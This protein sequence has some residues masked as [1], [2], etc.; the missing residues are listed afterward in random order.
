MTITIQDL[1]AILAAHLKWIRSEAGGTRANLA[2]ANL[3]GAD[4]TGAT[5]T[6]ANL[7]GANL[8]VAHLAGA[9]LFEANL[10]RANLYRANLYMADLTGADLTGAHLA[11]ANLTGATIREGLTISRA[12]LFVN[13]L[14][15]RVTIF[16]AHMQIGC[17]F[18]R[19]SDWQGFDNEQIAK[20][21]GRDSRKFW[22]A[23]KAPLL[24]MARA[25]GRDFSE[26]VTNEP[27]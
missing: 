2:G 10:Y 24:A 17:E 21:D 27:R 12:P 20:M 14:Q 4:L 9:N 18:H 1:P 11:G 23:F 16:D 5:L 8:T 26:E 22:D 6:R 25:D 19:L 15:Y 13:G 3:T 7:T